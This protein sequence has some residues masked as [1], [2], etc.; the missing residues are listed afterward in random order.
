VVQLTQ[1][2]PSP[3]PSTQPDQLGALHL[4]SRLKYK[5]RPAQTKQLQ[6]VLILSCWIISMV[7]VYDKLLQVFERA[8]GWDRILTDY[9]TRF[10]WN[11][12]EA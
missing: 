1:Q 3:K 12:V 7:P 4:K 5:A 2:V 6:L 10:Y 11:A 8:G 9:E